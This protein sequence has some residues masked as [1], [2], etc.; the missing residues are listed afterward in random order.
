MRLQRV[1]EP[2]EPG[3][4]CELGA[5]DAVV[6]ENERIVDGPALAGGIGFGV[7]DLAGD[8]AGLIAHPVFVGALAGVNGSSHCGL[9]T[10]GMFVP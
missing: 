8:R 1:H 3:A 5:A 4:R 10:E 2:H 7:V 9:P 6:D